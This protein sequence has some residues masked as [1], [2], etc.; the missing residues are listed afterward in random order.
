MR[1]EEIKVEINRAL[2]EVP[3]ELL[4]QILD[5]LKQFQTKDTTDPTFLKS[6]NKILEE[7][8]ELLKRLAQ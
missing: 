1:K 2:E 3:E 8:T 7:D 6:L 4:L 5:L